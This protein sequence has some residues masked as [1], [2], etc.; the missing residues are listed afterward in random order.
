M[1]KIGIMVRHQGWTAGSGNGRSMC[2]NEDAVTY[3]A[4]KRMQT[5][6]GLLAIVLPG[7]LAATCL[8]IAWESG[9]AH[10]V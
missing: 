6:V 9:Q 4:C 8:Y 7:S 3:G 10:S 5:T 2:W 1:Y